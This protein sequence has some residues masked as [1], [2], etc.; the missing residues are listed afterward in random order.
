MNGHGLVVRVTKVF[1]AYFSTDLP[2]GRLYVGMV[3]ALLC[4]RHLFTPSPLGDDG[5]INVT[6]LKSPPPTDAQRQGRR[7]DR[8]QGTQCHRL[9]A[10]LRYVPLHIATVQDRTSVQWTLTRVHLN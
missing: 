10:L 2:F 9:D 6:I 7:V 8:A 1:E 4:R 3:S 5:T